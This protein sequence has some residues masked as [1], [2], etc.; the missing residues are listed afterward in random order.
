MREYSFLRRVA[1]LIEQ[2][3]AGTIDYKRFYKDVK[4]AC[5][6]A[7]CDGIQVNKRD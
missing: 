2:V 3:E 1:T 4:V 7:K 6:R 5:E